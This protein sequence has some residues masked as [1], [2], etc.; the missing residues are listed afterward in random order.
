MSYAGVSQEDILI[1]LHEVRGRNVKWSWLHPACTWPRVTTIYMY[2]CIDVTSRAARVPLS[3]YPS[4]RILFL[5]YTALANQFN[6]LLLYD[7]VVITNNSTYTY[8]RF[9]CLGTR[10]T[11]R[12]T[13]AWEIVYNFSSEQ[14]FLIRREKKDC[15]KRNQLSSCILVWFL[16]I[17][18]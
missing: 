12:G 15:R 2:Y 10:W 7:I 18:Y 13:L 17:L 4:A 9:K 1:Y 3:M 11:T 6:T 14:Y 5:Q 8:L 16:F